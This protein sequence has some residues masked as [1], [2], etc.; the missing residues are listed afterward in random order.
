MLGDLNILFP[1]FKEFECSLDYIKH[2]K[3]TKSND[4]SKIVLDVSFS[5]TVCNNWRMFIMSLNTSKT[6][7]AVLGIRRFDL[8]ALITI[9]V[10][11]LFYMSGCIALGYWCT[12]SSS[13]S[14]TS[15]SYNLI[16][17]FFYIHPLKLGYILN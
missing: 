3:T 14:S 13:A 2:P 11:K 1:I 8:S 7:Y 5:N 12:Q 16:F 4:H 9:F 15:F 6:S 10:V 17:L